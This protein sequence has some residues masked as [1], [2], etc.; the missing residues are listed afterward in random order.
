MRGG[1]IMQESLTIEKTM[2]EA[3]ENSQ[4]SS[5]HS[6]L[7]AL[8]PGILMASA[9]VGGSHIVASTQAGAIYGW[10]LAIIIIL[11]N[12]CKYPF[13]RFGVHYTLSTNESLLQG[14]QRKGNLYLGVFFIL[15]VFAAMVNTA[16]VSIICAAILK[17]IFMAVGVNFAV[18]IPM[19]STMVIAITW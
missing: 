8:G 5:W 12:L 16:A 19:A 1:F 17:F 4:V 14:Y 9:A 15:N 11:A 10:Q 6:K 7:R 3:E 18:S 2:E 13:F